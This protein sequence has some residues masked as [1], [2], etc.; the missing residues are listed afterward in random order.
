MLVCKL[1]GSRARSFYTR[2]TPLYFSRATVYRKVHGTGPV[3]AVLVAP[4][5]FR[6]GVTRVWCDCD[7]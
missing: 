6:V 1:V 4:T 3:V 2:V 7:V 5:K